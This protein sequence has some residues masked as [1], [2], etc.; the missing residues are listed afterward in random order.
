MIVVHR[1]HEVLTEVDII[2]T[3]MCGLSTLA[4]LRALRPAYSRPQRT[5]CC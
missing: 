1:A 2:N 5:Q 3:N 4:S